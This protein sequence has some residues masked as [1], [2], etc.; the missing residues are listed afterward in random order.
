MTS[1]IITVSALVCDC[2]DSEM[3]DLRGVW[4]AEKW[5]E[6]RGSATWAAAIRR[7]RGGAPWSLNGYIIKL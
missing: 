6:A 3:S 2:L 7:A 1:T 4:R 5:R